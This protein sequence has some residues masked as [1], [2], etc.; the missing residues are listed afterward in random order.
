[1]LEAAGFTD[2]TFSRHHYDTFT[3]APL[4]SDAAEFETVGVDIR[5]GKLAT[6]IVTA[7]E[8]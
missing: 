3:D 7:R 2:V 8:E 1:M 6:P 4:S 5:A